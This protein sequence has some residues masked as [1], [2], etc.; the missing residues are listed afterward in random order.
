MAPE[1][2]VVAQ[3]LAVL[4]AG[5]GLVHGVDRL[6]YLALGLVVKEEL[7]GLVDAAICLGC[8]EPIFIRQNI[9]IGF[10]IRYLVFA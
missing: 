3:V 4:A 6:E 1:W 10:I 5:D 8:E 2:S 7:L 9:E